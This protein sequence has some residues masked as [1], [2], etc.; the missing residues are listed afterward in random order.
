MT[1][2]SVIID[3][4][5]RKYFNPID[6]IKDNI[7]D[8]AL[9]WFIIKSW[10]V[11][12]QE[13]KILKDFKFWFRISRLYPY[14]LWDSS[15]IIN[16]DIYFIYGVYKNSN[17]YLNKDPIREK[18]IRKDIERWKREKNY[19]SKGKDPWTVWLKLIDNWRGQVIKHELYTSHEVFERIKLSSCKKWDIVALLSNNIESIDGFKLYSI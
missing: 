18:H 15:K 16:W 13:S 9:F 14:D 6:A 7:A 5:N 4:T 1:I 2:W 10:Q 3:I 19:N 11:F 17:Y 8:D 12:E